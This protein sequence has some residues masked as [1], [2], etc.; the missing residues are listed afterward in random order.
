MTLTLVPTVVLGVLDPVYTKIAS[1]VAALPS[2]LALRIQKP[3]EEPVER[4]AVTMPVVVTVEPLYGEIRSCI[5]SV[6][7]SRVVGELLA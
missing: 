1:L 7:S 3:R 4:M 6:S 5:R 2:P